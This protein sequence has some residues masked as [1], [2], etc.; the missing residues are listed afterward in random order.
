MANKLQKFLKLPVPQ[1]PLSLLEKLMV[2]THFGGPAKCTVCGFFTLLYVR[3]GVIR[4]TCKCLNCRATNR[5]RQLAYFLYQTVNNITDQ[6]FSSLKELVKLDKS[7]LVIYSAE[8]NG[9]FHRYLAPYKGYRCSEYLG[10]DLKSGEI[11][12]GVMHQDLMALS[13]EDESI[14]LFLTSDVFEHIPDP[15]KAFQEI[16]RV[17]KK[18]GRHIFMVPFNSDQ[19]LDDKFARVDS[20]GQLVLLQ[21]PVYHGN[22]LKPTEGSLVY[23]IFGLEMLVK[24][25]EMNFQTNLYELHSRFHGIFGPQTLVF[26]AIKA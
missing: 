12:N 3:D 6:S 9:T 23:N 2:K 18:G 8:A 16:Y 24:L 19:L 20:D 5:Q 15:Y 25:A 17:L 7:G 11:V 26:E 14:D 21:P 1:A 13:F 22:P 4:E 10:D